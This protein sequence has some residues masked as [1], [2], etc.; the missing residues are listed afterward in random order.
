MA[1]LKDPPVHPVEKAGPH[2]FR[3]RQLRNERLPRRV[4]D[5]AAPDAPVHP[6]R[7]VPTARGRNVQ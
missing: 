3:R 2:A 4:A 1:D 7:E 5:A 6:Q